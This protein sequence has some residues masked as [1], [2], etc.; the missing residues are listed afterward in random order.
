MYLANIFALH[1]NRVSTPP[2]AT[3]GCLPG[4]TRAVLLEEL[5][6]SEFLFSER[7]LAPADLA[8]SDQVFITSTTRDLLPVLSID[9][10]PLRQAPLVLTECATSSAH[11]GLPMSL[12]THTRKRCWPDVRSGAQMSQLR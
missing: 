7:E 6:S 12:R 4:V 5:T 9:G 2:L 11:L 1:G 10:K 8:S 3:S